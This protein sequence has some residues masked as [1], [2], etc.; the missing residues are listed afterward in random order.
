MS[1]APSRKRAEQLEPRAELSHDGLI[2]LRR[3]RRSTRTRAKVLAWR[4]GRSERSLFQYETG[5]RRPPVAL[6]AEWRRALGME[7]G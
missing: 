2:A 3:A 5:S 7:D 6:L 4:I 1:T